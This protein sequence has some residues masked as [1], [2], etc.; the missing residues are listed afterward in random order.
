MDEFIFVSYYQ[1]MKFL[2]QYN[3]KGKTSVLKMEYLNT[4]KNKIY[5]LIMF[6][7]FKIKNYK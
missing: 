6:L 5:F 1:Q 3:F 4:L 7:I 2:E